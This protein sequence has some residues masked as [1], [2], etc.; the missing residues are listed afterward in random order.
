MGSRRWRASSAACR[1]APASPSS[2]ILPRSSLK[3]VQALAC[4]TAGAPLEGERL[5]LATASHAGTDRHVSVVR[6][7][8]DAAALG[9]DAL[10]C[11]PAWPGDQATRDMT[12]QEM[13]GRGNS[14]TPVGAAEFSKTRT[15]VRGAVAMAHAGDA[16]KADAQFY[17]TLAAAHRLDPDYVVFG[18]VISGM[19]VVLKIAPAD[20]IVRVTVRGAK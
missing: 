7:I 18:K 13:W 8:L 10:G 5:A 14:G 6:D 11:P 3:P 16:A 17:V 15:H 1:T 19:D 9:E 12:K 2:T 20:R 4:L